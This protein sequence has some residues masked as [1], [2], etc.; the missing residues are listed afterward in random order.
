MGV[1]H[2]SHRNNHD[3]DGEFYKEAEDGEEYK[4]VEELF[5]IWKSVQICICY[6]KETI[7]LLYFAIVAKIIK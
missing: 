7:N 2:F 4:W 1:D 3:Y 6:D 5:T